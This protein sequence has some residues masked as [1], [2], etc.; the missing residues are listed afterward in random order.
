MPEEKL[1]P[2][3]KPRIKKAEERSSPARY[4]IEVEPKV[5]NRLQTEL[6]EM[7]DVTF[8]R[9]SAD[10]YIVVIAPAEMI[11]IIRD[12][13]GVKKISADTLAW[14]SAFPLLFKEREDPWLGRVSLSNVE[15]EVSPLDVP[16]MTP[17]KAAEQAENIIY[18]TEYAKRYLGIPQDN[19]VGIRVAVL[20][21]GLFWP[22]PLMRKMV[23][24]N[25]FTDEMP[26]DGQGHG[27]WCSTAAF[28]DNALHPIYGTCVGMVNPVEQM[29]GKVLSNA[30]FG[31]TSWILDGMY[32]AVKE[33]GAKVISMS[34]GGPL[35]GSAIDDDPMCRLISDL[36][37][38]AIFVVAAGNSGPK[39]W[40]VGSPGASPDALTVASWGI[41]R[42]K[43]AGFS[44]RG[45]SGEF[46][47]EAHDTWNRDQSKVGNDLLKPD[48]A[49]P[50]GDD[51]AKEKLLSGC[52]GWYDP[53][54]DLHPQFGTMMGTSMA[55][56]LAAAMISLA[57]D[58][59]HINSAY[60]VKR[61][62]ERDMKSIHDGYGLLTWDRLVG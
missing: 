2:W 11:P 51:L 20:D 44:S 52:A 57:Y 32:F 15:I 58:R 14:I 10:R 1:N 12:M 7:K 61:K 41:T 18:T 36:K 46:Y 29:H 55:T 3:V 39:S 28:G 24:L 62:L 34:L 50:G 60:D 21:T 4:L 45:P 26:L 35:Q 48:I 37:N 19:D 22:H 43:V 38:D 16:L 49:C 5:L 13:S 42:N 31:M 54:A 59:G 25:S 53:V 23:Y 33:Y 8:I 30:G 27:T 9:T 56:P 6:D 40:T 17:I 47:K